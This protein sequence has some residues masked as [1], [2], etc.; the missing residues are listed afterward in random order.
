MITQYLPV[1]VA[2]IIAVAFL[3]VG[4]SLT[5]IFKGHNIESEISD[6]SEMKKRGIKCAS[7]QMRDQEKK[8]GGDATSGAC[9]PS[10][11]VDVLKNC[12]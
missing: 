4:L 6:N 8:N 10:C 12:H 11:S 7:Q 5:L 2:A 3:G 1:I 9:C